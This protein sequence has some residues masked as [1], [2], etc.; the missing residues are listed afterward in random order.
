MSLSEVNGLPC[1]QCAPWKGIPFLTHGFLTRQ[2]G[3]SPSPYATLNVGPASGDEPQHLRE[4]LC[5]IA[6]GFQISPDRIFCARQEHKAS[7]ARVRP[8]HLSRSFFSSQNPFRCDGLVTDESD[9]FLGILTADC[10]PILLLDP[11]QPA[12]GAVHAGWRGTLH[13][14]A[15]HI[16][17][18]MNKLFASKPGKVQAAIGPAVGPCC[19][20][21]REEVAAAFSKADPRY[22]PFI[23]NW[24]HGLYRLDLPGMNRH[25]LLAGGVKAENIF[26]CSVCTCCRPDLFFSLRAQGHPTGRQLSLIGLRNR[27]TIQATA[28]EGPEQIA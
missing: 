27:L 6:A 21:V 26:L 19:Y 2:G 12:V 28:R 14:V 4:N 3:V 10:V 1:Y 18:R 15:T 8:S 22:E 20:S 13:A 16:I 7:I 23:H 25:Q 9:V 5:R 24:G 17:E 11:E